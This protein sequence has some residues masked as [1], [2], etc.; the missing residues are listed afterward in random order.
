[1]PKAE[2][3]MILKPREFSA[4][5]LLP[6]NSDEL[7]KFMEQPLTAIAESITGALAAG[8]KGWMMMTGRIVQGI[9]KGRLFQRLGQEVKKLREDGKI[10]EDFA[11][12]KKYKYGFKSWVE[13]L[14][15]IDE[16]TPDADRL[17]ALKAMF[18]GVNKI[19]ATDG[20]RIL[21]Y[22]LLQTAKKLTSS[23][24]L[25][26][27]AIFETYKGCN[28]VQDQNRSTPLLV[29]ATRVAGGLGHGAVA[30]V[31]RDEQ[32]LAAQG[33]ISPRLGSRELP[34]ANQS[35]IDFNAR[36]TDLGIR[37]CHNIETYHL[38]TKL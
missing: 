4:D 36:L 15:T 16:E 10:P 33:L 18:Y 31:L 32:V 14:Q 25:V 38:E 11:D 12:E 1:M 37:F 35:V 17:E 2:E 34:E 21:N 27:R 23:E 3:S 8:P 30:L 13:L 19:N 26:L 6:E 5:L 9:L 20:E 29:W 28:Y 7:A 22:Q 24:L